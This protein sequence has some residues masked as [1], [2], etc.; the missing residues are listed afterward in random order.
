MVFAE[1]N[2][3]T[4]GGALMHRHHIIPRYRGGSDDESNL[5][6]PISIQEHAELHR[7]LWEAEGYPEDFIAWKALSGRMTS[8]E[9]RLAAAKEGQNRSEI[10]RSSRKVTGEILK[11]SV[12][13]E[14]RSAGGKIASAAL[15]SWQREN[16]EQHRSQCAINGRVK[17]PKQMIPHLYL[18]EVYPSKRELQNRHLMSNCGFYGKLNRGEIIRMDNNV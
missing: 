12:T 9:A 3:Q 7:Q 2:R 6:P 14:S 1:R 4:E 16:S 13:F 17:G 15:V 10:Y 5:T 11:R 8:E 18:G